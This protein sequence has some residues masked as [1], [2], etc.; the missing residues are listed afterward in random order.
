MKIED[1][2]EK[3]LIYLEK[4]LNYSPMTI[5]DYKRDLIIYKDFLEIKKYNY[6]DINKDEII[7]YLKYLDSLKH[8]N[9]SISRHLSALRSFYN[10]LVDVKLL[11]ENIFRR[12][13]NPKVPKK[14][15][16]YLSIVEIENILDSIDTSTKEGI[17]DKCIFELL[18]STGIRVS[19]LCNIK[20]EDID[21]NDCSIR[22]MG[23]GNKERIVYFGVCAQKI[24]D[25]YLKVRS[26]Y[27]IK[28]EIPYLLVNKLGGKMSRESVE[29][30]INRIM[31]R[32][33]NVNHK[34]S[35]HT[36]RH[37]YATHLLDEGADLRSVQELL[38]HENLDTTQIYTHV[39]N[40]RLRAVYLQCHPNKKRQ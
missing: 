21:M 1:A 32:C 35:P 6:L 2:I 3:F 29:Y 4:E 5:I 15:P 31:I 24:L 36:L 30:L 26:A 39:S 10:F 19:E 13:K 38:G 23:K 12:I 20:L 33:N 22:I 34:I 25:D 18:Y 28:G 40:E 16:N 9:K 27:L 17:R 7:A 11:E 8:S 14:L 37:S